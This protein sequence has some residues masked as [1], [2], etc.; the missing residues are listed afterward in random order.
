M[1]EALLAVA[2]DEPGHEAVD[3]LPAEKK[4]PASAL[5]S[6][7]ASIV[8]SAS[9]AK[10]SNAFS[11][12]ISQMLIEGHVGL[13]WSGWSASRAGGG[14]AAGTTDRAAGGRNRGC[15]PP[16]SQSS[17]VRQLFENRLVEDVQIEVVVET[18]HRVPSDQV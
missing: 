7:S 16:G 18:G 5:P 10:N 4:Q 15:R 2:A 17:A 1:V 9:T 11:M 3:A 6:G 8:S 13:E 12:L 14:H